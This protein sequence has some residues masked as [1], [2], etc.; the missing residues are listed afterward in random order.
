MPR[1]DYRIENR[2]GFAVVSNGD[3]RTMFWVGVGNAADPRSRDRAK[4]I[5]GEL[6]RLLSDHAGMPSNVRIIGADA[7]ITHREA[8]S[9]A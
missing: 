7:V 4:F 2:E 8:S 3:N 1:I 5:A 9:P 6:V